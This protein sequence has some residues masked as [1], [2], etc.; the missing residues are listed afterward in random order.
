VRSLGVRTA[1]GLLVRDRTDTQC[2]ALCCRSCR[3]PVS[4]A[5]SVGVCWR[6]RLLLSFGVLRVRASYFR[7]FIY[8]DRSEFLRCGAFVACFLAEVS[9]YSI[10]IHKKV[11]F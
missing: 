3:S 5:V 2:F 8:M 7:P 6:C 1:A 11:Y 9:V 4:V 10:T